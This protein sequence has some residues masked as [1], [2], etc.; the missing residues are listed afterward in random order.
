MHVASRP[1]MANAHVVGTWLTRSL[2][3][4][5]VGALAIPLLLAGC[6]SNADS[7][8]GSGGSAGEGS[9]SGGSGGTSG[10]GSSGD[11]GD[12]G[13]DF[14]CESDAAPGPLVEVPAGAFIM[15]CNDDV[16]S[17][18]VD[19]ELPMHMV[20]LSAFEIERTEVTQDAYAACVTAGACDPPSCSWDCD[21]TDLPATCVDFDQANTFASGRTGASRPKPNGRKLLAARLV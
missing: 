5:V 16:D 20:T 8:D 2:V 7:D 13:N 19:D 3:V 18:C 14:A 6:G 17:E 4:R 21:Q 12:S 10:S 1:A 15:G 9:S 11:A